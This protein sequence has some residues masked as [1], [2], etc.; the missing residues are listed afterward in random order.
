[1]TRHTGP[2]RPVPAP[3]AGR[4]PRRVRQPVTGPI[5]VASRSTG[6]A[7]FP[8]LRLDRVGIKSIFNTA[9]ALGTVFAGAVDPSGVY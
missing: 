2:P 8:C 6:K 5:C 3:T 9:K 1:M 7:G 4:P